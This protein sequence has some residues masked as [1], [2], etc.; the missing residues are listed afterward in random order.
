MQHGTN[1]SSAGA[2]LAPACSIAE[3]WTVLSESFELEAAPRHGAMLLDIATQSSGAF[4]NLQSHGIQIGK[5]LKPVEF[6]PHHN[7]LG[8]HDSGINQSIQ[9]QQPSAAR[10]H[11]LPLGR[12]PQS[13]EVLRRRGSN[14]VA[15]MLPCRLSQVSGSGSLRTHTAI[16]AVHRILWQHHPVALHGSKEMGT[17]RAV[18]RRHGFTLCLLT[19]PLIIHSLTLACSLAMHGL[20]CQLC[21]VEAARLSIGGLS[22]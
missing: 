22:P 5:T 11:S 15:A 3:Q 13:P 8:L 18:P 10:G 20:L 17:F 12:Q 7:H 16:V 1:G 2:C 21:C 19:N 6:R 9:V 4:A 14:V